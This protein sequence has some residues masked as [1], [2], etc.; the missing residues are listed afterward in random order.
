MTIF[1]PILL[2]PFEQ[3]EQDISC[4]SPL[5]YIDFITSFVNFKATVKIMKL[6]PETRLA[7][8][9]KVLRVNF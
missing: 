1:S 8:Q 9:L 4:I 2:N 7:A 5:I 3:Q 6:D